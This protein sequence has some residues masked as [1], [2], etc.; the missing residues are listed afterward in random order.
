[1]GVDGGQADRTDPLARPYVTGLLRGEDADRVAVRGD[2][3][4]GAALHDPCRAVLARQLPHR[5]ADLGEL[6]VPAA[7]Q[8][9]VGVIEQQRPAHLVP[10]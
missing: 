6:V 9:V 7:A 4:A 5:P 2:R 8:H 3:E 10:R 1:M